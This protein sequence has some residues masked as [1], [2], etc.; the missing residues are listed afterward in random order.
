[1]TDLKTFRNGYYFDSLEELLH[2]SSVQGVHD[3]LFI[4]VVEA[5]HKGADCF[6]NEKMLEM[7]AESIAFHIALF[8]EMERQKQL[9]F[10]LKH[11]NM[12][13]I[14]KCLTLEHSLNAL[15]APLWNTTF[16]NT[17]QIVTD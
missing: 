13:L 4:K 9:S 5:K 17:I 1:M 14:N 6:D 12:T 16:K 10:D 3:A 2:R 11:L 7:L 8:A 15:N